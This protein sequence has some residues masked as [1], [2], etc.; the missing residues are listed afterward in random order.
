MIRAATMVMVMVAPRTCASVE[1]A[2][3]KDCERLLMEL[4]GASFHK[5]V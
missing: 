1:S 2:C 3:Y 4:A 5:F